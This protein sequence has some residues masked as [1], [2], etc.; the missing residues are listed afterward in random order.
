MVQTNPDSTTAKGPSSLWSRIGLGTG[1]L[2]S[3]G[4]AASLTEV[5]T[6]LDAMV[7]MGVSVIDTADTYGSGDCEILLGRALRRNPNRFAVVTK[8]GYRLSNLGGPLRHLNQF[9]KKAAHKFGDRQCFDADYLPQALERS[10]RRLGVDH[11]NAFLLHDPPLEVIRDQAVIAACERIGKSGRADRVGVSS[12]DP[13]VLRE[14]I[15]SQVFRVVETPANLGVAASLREVWD[16]CGDSDIRLIA[17]HVF[18]PQCL[19][20]PGMTHQ[21]LMRACAAMVPRD[22]T[23]LCGTRNPLHLRE[24]GDWAA[25]PMNPTEAWELV[26]C[27]GAAQ[28]EPV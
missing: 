2:A 4:R 28:G 6:L 22:G 21:L 18:A 26:S 10:L 11:V 24:A 15:A 27:S 17:N 5:V 7:E 19:E 1:T 3:L 12:G 8:A 9:I 25:D 13:H 14:A 20:V 23:I 16:A